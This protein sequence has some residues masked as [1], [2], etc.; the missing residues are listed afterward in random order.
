MTVELL[1]EPA[2]NGFLGAVERHRRLKLTVRQLRQAFDRSGNAGVSLDVVVPRREIGV[3]NRPVDGDTFLAVRLEIEIAEPVTLA[4]PCERSATE[5]ITAIP[6]EAFDLAIWRFLFVHPPVEILLVERIVAL[7][8]GIRVDHRARPAGAM[9]ILPLSFARVRVTLLMFD[10]LA[11]LEQEHAQATLG[12]LFR[13]PSTRDARSDHDR[14]E[15]FGWSLH[16]LL[17]ARASYKISGDGGPAKIR[18]T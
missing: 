5:V 18:P 16:C 2:G 12:Q 6:V 13:G 14:V 7:Q 10:V 4:A 1:G 8:H 15:V 9:R 17:L 11:A 3:A